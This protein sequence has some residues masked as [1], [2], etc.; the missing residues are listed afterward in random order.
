MLESL[1]HANA[2]FRKKKK[3]THFDEPKKSLEGYFNQPAGDLFLCIDGEI[4]I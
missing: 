3:Q 4:S 1:Y 2:N